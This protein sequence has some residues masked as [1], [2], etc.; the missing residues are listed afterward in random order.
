MISPSCLNRAAGCG[1]DAREPQLGRRLYENPGDTITI[2]G[3]VP[4]AGDQACPSGDGIGLTSMAD[5]FPPDGFGPA[6]APDADGDFEITYTIPTGTP[7]GTYRIGMR[8]GAGDDRL[9]VP[10]P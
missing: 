10:Q 3:N 9:V 4:V 7:P 5:L 8:C 6:V 2:S 1:V